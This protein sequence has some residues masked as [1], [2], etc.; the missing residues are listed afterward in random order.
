[1][2]CGGVPALVLGF[3]GAI[4][5]GVGACV[6]FADGPPNIRFSFVGAC[7]NWLF[8]VF[9]VPASPPPPAPVQRSVTFFQGVLRPMGLTRSAAIACTRVSL[10]TGTSS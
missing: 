3:A 2:R 1:N 9:G 8:D 7:G 5:G 4:D 6:G 10:V